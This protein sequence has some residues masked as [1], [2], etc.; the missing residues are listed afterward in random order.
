MSGSAWLGIV[1][2]LSYSDHDQHR[3]DTLVCFGVLTRAASLRT[4]RATD[5]TA[6]VLGKFLIVIQSK[7]ID[8]PVV[9]LFP[10]L[11]YCAADSSKRGIAPK[12]A[13]RYL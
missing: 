1:T 12:I 3:K 2:D 6:S 11:Q 9:C 4:S 7:D 5:I 8:N 13:L 10:P